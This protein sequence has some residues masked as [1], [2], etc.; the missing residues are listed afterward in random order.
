MALRGPQVRAVGNFP[1]ELQAVP[2]L[3]LTPRAT[4]SHQ[5]CGQPE[6]LKGKQLSGECLACFIR[7][8]FPF[9]HLDKSR[10]HSYSP[11]L[12]PMVSSH[13]CGWAAFISAFSS[14][15]WSP[16]HE[17]ALVCVERGG[18]DELAE[19][20]H[21]AV[22]QVPPWHGPRETAGDQEPDV[23]ST[24]DNQELLG[25]H[26]EQAR[27]VSEQRIY[28]REEWMIH[29]IPFAPSFKDCPCLKETGQEPM[30]YITVPDPLLV[31][32]AGTLSPQ[33]S[34]MK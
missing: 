33:G 30:A 7:V 9:I 4:P 12:C 18:L 13:C 20:G 23:A 26:L 14:C 11:L 32:S 5:A 8:I 29:E 24:E 10:M 31:S 22:L 15:L 1:R 19:T 28:L 2:G 25:H 34:D 3:F 21:A 27:E 17:P 6:S 16:A